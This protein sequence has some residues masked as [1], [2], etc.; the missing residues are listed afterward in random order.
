MSR[1][2]VAKMAVAAALAATGFGAAANGD[3]IVFQKDFQMTAATPGYVASYGPGQGV[4]FTVT[5]L[6]TPTDN[7]GTSRYGTGV[8]NTF[9]GYTAYLL[10]ATTN[11]SKDNNWN[12]AALEMGGVPNESTGD[13][14]HGTF[15]QEWTS[16]RAG[17]SSTPYESTT[18][19]GSY[20][21][22][23]THWTQ[24]PGAAMNPAEAG[25]PSEN[26]ITPVTIANF[27]SAGGYLVTGTD[28]TLI[29]TYSIPVAYQSN[30]VDIAYMVVPTGSP[31]TFAGLVSTINNPTN[32]YA[33][34]ITF[35]GSI[36]ATAVPEPTTLALAAVAGLGILT[37][38]RKRKQA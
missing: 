20:Y 1:F 12:I 31:V 29:T 38:G 24:Q 14:L 27:D 2:S 37:L 36:N 22:G 33:T 16:T 8:N 18:S 7:V 25:L 19:S 13:G 17:T 11:T 34:L 30:S 10:S 35:S 3:T 21:S 4:T 6:G 32:T 26:A 28:T 23:D 15:L 9:T 5:D